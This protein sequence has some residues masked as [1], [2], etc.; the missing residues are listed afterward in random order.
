MQQYCSL[1]VQGYDCPASH[2]QLRSYKTGICGHHN[3]LLRW[4]EV[5]AGSCQHVLRCHS[6]D[7]LLVCEQVVL[8]HS[9]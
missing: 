5:P 9:P 1:K 2:F 7:A 4:V 6:F 8:Q 3:S